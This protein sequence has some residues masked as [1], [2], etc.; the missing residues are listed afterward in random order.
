MRLLSSA[1]PSFPLFRRANASYE[2]ALV[3]QSQTSLM[4]WPTSADGV[5][6]TADELPGM[7]VR[8]RQVPGHGAIVRGSA[9]RPSSWTAL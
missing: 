6:L 1:R 2:S 5:K 7:S 9:A 3:K 8:R 4:H